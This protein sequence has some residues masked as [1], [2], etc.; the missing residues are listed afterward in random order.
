M[1]RAPTVAIDWKKFSSVTTGRS[2][3]EQMNGNVI[4]QLS[5]GSV[6]LA[7][8]Q[9][10]SNSTSVG[11]VDQFA[12]QIPEESMSDTDRLP[13]MNNNGSLTEGMHAEPEL[14]HG[15]RAVIRPFH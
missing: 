11:I 12:V 3:D 15:N 10:G 14:E 1:K 2:R 7:S 5:L 13:S 4:F 8:L 9:D 6:L